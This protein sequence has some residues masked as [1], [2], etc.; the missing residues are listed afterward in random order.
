[1]TSALQRCIQDSL[2]GEFGLMELRKVSQRRQHFLKERKCVYSNFV[3]FFKISVLSRYQLRLQSKNIWF[4]LWGTNLYNSKILVGIL[5]NIWWINEYPEPLYRS[6]NNTY[7]SGNVV[8]WW[9]HMKNKKGNFSSPKG[10]I[11]PESSKSCW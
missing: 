8:C 5:I 3:Y 9:P 4:L 2:E 1:M 7:L 10:M 6:T 11:S